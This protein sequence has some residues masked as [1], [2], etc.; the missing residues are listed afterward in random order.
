LENH[1]Y[2]SQIEEEAV[3]LAKFLGSTIRRI[4]KTPIYWGLKYSKLNLNKII[5]EII[6]LLIRESIY[7]II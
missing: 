7:D 1:F 5:I 3:E 2:L 6:Y 4:V